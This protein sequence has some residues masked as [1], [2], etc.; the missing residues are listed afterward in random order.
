MQKCG[1]LS[2]MHKKKIQK[3]LLKNVLF[4]LFLNKKD[5]WKKL[6][7]NNLLILR[8]ADWK[9]QMNIQIIYKI[10]MITNWKTKKK[11]T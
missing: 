6:K 1:L 9:K 7:Q 8:H 2:D 5:I 11:T 3:L 4:I 10:Q